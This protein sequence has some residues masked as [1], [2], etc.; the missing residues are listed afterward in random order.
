[1]PLPSNLSRSNELSSLVTNTIW[2][3]TPQRTSK[4]KQIIFDR[5][6]SKKRRGQL[7]A[8]PPLCTPA[9]PRA[10]CSSGLQVTPSKRISSADRSS[11]APESALKSSFYAGAKFSAA[12]K[13]SFLP[14]P[15]TH[16]L[17]STSS[18]DS[19]SSSDSNHSIARIDSD[20]RSGQRVLIRPNGPLP[21]RTENCGRFNQT[22]DLRSN[23]LRPNHACIFAT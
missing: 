16:W 9:S 19:I 2:Q 5:G 11:P 4:F 22:N 12:P 10:T 13:P 18:V 21:L 20:G 15:P 17:G 8:E 7:C 1:M 23:H 6:Y 3:R 14:K